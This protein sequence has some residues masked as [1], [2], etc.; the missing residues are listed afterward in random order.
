MDFFERVFMRMKAPALAPCPCR[1]S[2]FSRRISRMKCVHTR[3]SV[4]RGSRRMGR[5]WTPSL[6]RGAIAAGKAVGN[7]ADMVTAVGLAVGQVQ[8]MTEDSTDRRANRVQDTKRLIGNG[9]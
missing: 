5:R 3:T 2:G 7:E 8:D 1:T 6:S 9:R 4:G